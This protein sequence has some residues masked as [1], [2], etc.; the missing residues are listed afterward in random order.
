MAFLFCCIPSLETKRTYAQDNTQAEQPKDSPVARLDSKAPIEPAAR[1][2]FDAEE[3]AKLQLIGDVRRDQ[4]GP[5][6]PEFPEM[7]PGNTAVQVDADS[8]LAVADPGPNSVYDFTNGDAITLEAWVQPTEIRDGE[9]RYVIGKGRTGSSKFTRDNQNWALRIAGRK[10]QVCISFLFATALSASDKHWHRWTSDLSFAPGTGWHH[11]AV[12][13]RFGEPESIRGWVNGQA[14]TGTWDMG[15]P[16]TQPPVV[17]DDEI[18]I[19]NRF[20]GGLDAIAIHRTQLD[21]ATMTGRFKRIGGERVVKL[22]PEMMPDLGDIPAGQVLFQLCENMPAIDRWLY[23]SESPPSEAVRWFGDSFLLPRIPA[24]FD[25]WGIR[26]SWAAP[27]LL[28]IAGDVELPT[29][30]HHILTRARSRSRLWIDGELVATLKTARRRTGNLEPIVPVPEPLVSDARLLP[31][32][33]QEEIVEYE[34]PATG[35]RKSRRSRIVLEVIIGG[36][37]RRT[38]TGEV[39]VAIQL[40]PDQTSND[41]NTNDQ[42]SKKQTG[43]KL[44][45]RAPLWILTTDPSQRLM[46]TDAAIEPKLRRLESSLINLEDA[47]RRKAAQSQDEFWNRRHELAK[48]LAVETI[49]FPETDFLENKSNQPIDN[50]IASKFSQALKQTPPADEIATKDFHENVLPILETQCFRCHGEKEQGGLKLNSRT[51]A[52]SP[53]D[54]GFPAVVPGYPDASEL[55]LRVQS[56]EMPPTEN[57]LTEQQIATLESW[58]KEG[59]QWPAAP[60]DPEPVTQAQIIDDAAFLRRAYL[61]VIGVGPTELQ[62]RTFLD[63]NNPNKRETLVEQLLD[64]D[65]YADHWV[66]FWMDLLAENPTLLNQSLNSTGPFR[67]FLHDSLRDRKPVDRMVTELI[68]M[69]GSPH[70]GG[71]A[72]FGLAGEND[73]PMAAKAHILSAAFLGIE[74]QC[75]RCHDSPYHSTTQ[76]DLFAVAAMLSRKQLAPPETSRVPKAFFT[77]IGRESLIKVTLQPDEQVS[78][79]WPFESITEVKDGPEIDVL[80]RDPTDSRERLAAL[81]T[82]P[83]NRLF[84]KVIVNHLWTRLLGG[85]LVQPVQDWE[86]NSPSHPGLLDWLAQELVSHQYDLRHVQKLI[87]TSSVYQRQPFGRN[88]SAAAEKRFFAAPDPRR[89][90]AEQIVDSL[91]NASGREMDTEEL[92][93]VHDGS[94]P[95]QNRLT[96]GFPNRAWML[97]SLNNERDR[98]SLSMPKAQPIVDVLE[99]FGWNGTRQQPIYARANDPNVLQPG[100]LSGGTLAMSLTRA[101]YQSPLANLAIES[102]S[103]EQLLDSLFLRFYARYPQQREKEFFVPVLADRFDARIVDTA[104]VDPAPKDDPLPVSTWSNHLLPEANEIQQQWQD[105]VRRGPPVDPRLAPSWRELYE[106]V[107][108]SLVND[109]EFVWIP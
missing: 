106:D 99:A 96:L 103:A 63:N 30:T 39:C 93:F 24:K 46:L 74:L 58:I 14:T 41:Q 5:R 31:F 57:G 56:G 27:L 66:G 13:Y 33:Q 94:H 102:T 85:G 28:R 11:I 59:A 17:D 40:G 64:D 92:T 78:P 47:M 76:K 44:H 77:N 71:S 18:R 104:L 68:L 37:G 42:H 69:R 45:H 20:S 105:R 7:D 50:F 22:A 86:A 1:W 55:I 89:L 108:W 73:A 67:W 9:L 6:P 36:S 75:A 16:T 101:S 80:M 87:M 49:K 97:A 107:I 79:T 12:S 38:E 2:E 8:Y 65:G 61:D 21:D 4:T 34:V 10:N 15:G 109:R 54:S 72:G 51:N 84:P 35:D 32:P 3:T 52:L 26:S 23:E 29:G 98:P 25:S 100:I 53:G 88:Q 83:Q 62:A 43:K 82:A 60:V 48:R 95:I 90:T 19:G 91:F 81:I 70:E